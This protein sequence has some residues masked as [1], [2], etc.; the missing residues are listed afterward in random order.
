MKQQIQTAEE[1]NPDLRRPIVDLEES[2]K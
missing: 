1:F 2:S